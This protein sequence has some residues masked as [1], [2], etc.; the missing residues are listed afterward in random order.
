MAILN[1]HYGKPNKTIHMT[2]VS[3][4]GTEKN[5]YECTKTTYSPETGKAAL[6]NHEV[7][8]VDC[9]H[10]APTLPPCIDMPA[11]PGANAVPCSNEGSVRLVNVHGQVSNSEGRLEYCLNEKY[12]PLCKADQH[13]GSAVCR[14]NGYTQYSCKPR[15]PSQP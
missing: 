4:T 1:S 3:C 10:D 8:G 14:S 5:L 9:L 13:L 12:T 15:Q 7:A 11:N 6:P 2:D